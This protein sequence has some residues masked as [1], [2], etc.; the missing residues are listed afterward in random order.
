M[1]DDTP[2]SKGLVAKVPLLQKMQRKK[3]TGFVILINVQKQ[4]SK[5][6]EP[7]LFHRPTF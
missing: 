6:K 5:K 4:G 7:V 1:E 3:D 2:L